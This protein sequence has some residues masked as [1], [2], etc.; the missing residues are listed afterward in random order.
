[1]ATSISPVSLG[2][3][4]GVESGLSHHFTMTPV[5]TSL[6]AAV[7]AL[8]AI[9]SQID[10]AYIEATPLEQFRGG[11]HMTGGMGLRNQWHLW[12]GDGPLHRELTSLG[13]S[14]GDDRSGLILSLLW[15]RV[16]GTTF[17]IVAEAKTN[18]LHWAAQGLLPDGRPL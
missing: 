8:E 18:R 15:A 17:D 1:M 3:N 12:D 16:N 6:A 2:R 9:L 11:I 10:R 5:P 14:H 4:A 7:D 13:F